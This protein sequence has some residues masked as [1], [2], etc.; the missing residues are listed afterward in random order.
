MSKIA[1]FVSNYLPHPGGLEVMVW[2]LARGLARR[3]DVVLVTSAYDGVHGVSN[4]D[5]MTVHRLPAVHVT[6]RFGVPYPV[7]AGPGLRAAL[8][9]VSGAQIV[10]SHGALYAQSILARSLAR[11]A[12]TPF[13]LT[14]HVGFVQ[15]PS[16]ALNA[17][18]RAAWTAIG[19]PLVRSADAV[20][21]YNARVHDELE[22]R[23]GRGVR[24]VGNGVD[25]DRFGPR[26][27]DE[28]RAL[29]RSFGLPEEGVLALFAGRDSEK[30]NLD[31]LLRAERAGYTLVVCGWQRNLTGQALVDLGVVPY[32]RMSDLFA[33]ADVMLHP[34]SGEGFPLAVQEAVA[35]GLPV[36]LLWDEGYA[37]W[38]PRTLVEACDSPAQ[39][40][41]R[42][43]EL[44]RD[45]ARRQALGEAGRAWAESQWNWDATVKA[46]ERIYDD[47]ADDA[48]R[49]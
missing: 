24:F 9:D 14:E 10:H 39:V 6:E 34:A 22:R 18:Q 2:N 33:C 11:R 27:C 7:P 8:R 19:T 15:Y 26:S 16:A 5:G 49:N 4:E 44:A 41:S 3:H 42:M 21:T 23:S 12:G 47:V 38:M 36:V 35:S 20:V 28:R 46:Y 43:E 45:P 48:L 17:I 29:R 40:P 37:R 1:M 25:I 31:V 32:A 13:V 30:K